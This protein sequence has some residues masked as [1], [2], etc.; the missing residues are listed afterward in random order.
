MFLPI[1]LPE[2]PSIFSAGSENSNRQESFYKTLYRVGFS[3]SLSTVSLLPFWEVP[4]LSVA[5]VAGLAPAVAAPPEEAVLAPL[6]EPPELFC[7]RVTVR[8]FSSVAHGLAEPGITPPIVHTC[9]KRTII[10]TCKSL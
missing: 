6:V 5:E 10:C 4:L 8:D 9:K 2:F 3:P 7:L 1:K